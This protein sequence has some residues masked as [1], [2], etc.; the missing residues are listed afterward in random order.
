MQD[1]NR[2]KTI[3]IIMM[4]NRSF[5]NMLGHLSLPRHGNR[6]EIDGLTKDL[7]DEQYENIFE[8]ETYYPHKMKDE[9]LQLDLPHNRKDIEK[10][11][12]SY[13]SVSRK[14]TMSGFVESYFLY[15]R[16]RNVRTNLRNPDP[17]GFYT[18]NEVP[19]TNFL[20]NNFSVCNR[21]FSPLPTSTVPNRL[22]SL[23]GISRV[24]ETG[25]FP[26]EGFIL[27]DW[28]TK[29]GIRWRV[30]HEG[31][32]FFAILGRFDDIFLSGNFRSTKKL[33][34]D[35]K[36]EPDEEFPEVILIEPSYYDAPRVF[37]QPNDNHAPLAV[38]FGED[39][40]RRIYIDLTS[41][42]ERW[43][44]TVV[45]LT[46][47][48]HGGFFDHVPPLPILYKPPS[49]Q[50]RA[51][52]STGVR[53]PSIVISPF[54]SARSVFNGNLDHTSILQFIAE[55]FDPRSGYSKAVKE[56][57][58]LGI[59]SV[60]KVLDLN[61]PRNDIPEIPNIAM[62]RTAILGMDEARMEKGEMENA[63]KAACKYMVQERPTETKQK[64]P[65]LFRINFT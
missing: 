21:W 53:V 4:E 18:S 27:T 54:V 62:K 51:F 49:N 39:F 45:I 50:Y 55:R 59:E 1:L 31:V 65:E 61:T 40:L 11:Q 26:K 14:Y 23:S 34:I 24:D 42:P 25:L 15:A 16:E 47:D 56:R 30:Y 32:S 52:K 57:K 35:V 20:A 63:F 28:L 41:N 29:R 6:K 38:G 5:D 58:K 10:I 7:E 43:K 2:I 17:M 36:E 33:A 19:I 22:F 37:D 46:Y 12:L 48:E 60:S 13:S 9:M 44:K 64:Y 8:G 3:V